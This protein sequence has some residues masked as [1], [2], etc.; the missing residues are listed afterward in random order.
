MATERTFSIIKPDATKRNIT[1]K[2]KSPSSRKP[3]CGLSPSAV[4][5]CPRIKQRASTVSIVSAR[6]LMIWS[7]S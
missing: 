7:L 4:F 1:G 5:G 2:I 3:A 6:S